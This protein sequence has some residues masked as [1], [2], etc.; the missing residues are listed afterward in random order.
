M[1]PA[2]YQLEYGKESSDGFFLCDADFGFYFF[3]RLK[4]KGSDFQ[5]SPKITGFGETMDLKIKDYRLVKIQRNDDWICALVIED[6]WSHPASLR[7]VTLK[8]YS[9]WEPKKISCEEIYAVLSEI[10]YLPTGN[11]MVS[12]VQDYISVIEKTIRK[13]PEK[14]YFFRGHY[15]Y[16]YLLVP[17]LYRKKVYYENENLMYMDFKTQFYNELSHKKYIE[18][19]TTMQHYK[20]P[21]RL[22]DTTSNPLVALFMACDCPTSYKPKGPQISEV[23]TMKESRKNVRYSDS[24]TVTLL[25]CLSVLETDFKQE[26]YEKIVES[27]QKNDPSIYQNCLAFQRFVAEVKTELPTFDLAIF[28]P[29]VLL[30]PKHVRVGMINERMIA[31]SG[32]FILFGLCDYKTGTYVELDTV[33]KERIF[34]V[35]QEEIA[36]Q[37]SMLNIN[38]GTMYP[39][40]DHMSSTITKQYD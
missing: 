13:N 24:T 12:N 17:S 21:T 38:T 29:E 9:E 39:D 25:S 19:L 40:K 27:I 28:S 33:I 18:I 30:K 32:N 15:N 14:E 35:N 22:L 16:K 6:S 7:T 23:V 20:M 34:V 3:F 10:C 37:L 36:K 31:Q 4:K 8:E 5:E 11:Y 1:K 26:L 2:E